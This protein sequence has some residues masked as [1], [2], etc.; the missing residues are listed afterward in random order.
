MAID[1]FS[2]LCAKGGVEVGGYRPDLIVF[3]DDYIARG[4]LLAMAAVGIRIPEDVQVVTMANKGL[5]PVWLKPLTQFEVDSAAEAEILSDLVRDCLSD[6]GRQH[7]ATTSTTFIVGETTRPLEGR[8][9]KDEGR[10]TRG[11]PT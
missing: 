9:T 4:A 2:R 5:G 3:L 1:D 7:T 6:H 8:T 10:T 11:T